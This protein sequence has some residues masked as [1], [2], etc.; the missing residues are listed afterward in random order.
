MQ[1]FIIVHLC[2]CFK[3]CDHRLGEVCADIC[4]C[5]EL[6]AESNA[7]NLGLGEGWIGLGGG[8]D[9]T[10]GAG[11]SVEGRKLYIWG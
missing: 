1:T 3:L 4:W 11:R 5:Q 10:W 6:H 7:C 8:V 2:S 9:G